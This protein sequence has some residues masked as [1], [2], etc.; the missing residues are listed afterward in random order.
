MQKMKEHGLWIYAVDTDNVD[1]IICSFKK[2]YHP[3]FQGTFKMRPRGRRFI[4]EYPVEQ[5]IGS[6]KRVKVNLEISHFPIL[7]NFATT[8]HK[9]QGKTMA[10]LVIAQWRDTE[11]GHT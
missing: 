10:N 5:A 1:H 2:S 9:M 3:K 6:K 4:V 8:G 11:N 7:I